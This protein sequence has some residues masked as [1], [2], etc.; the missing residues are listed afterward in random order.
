[1]AAAMTHQPTKPAAMPGEKLDA[2]KMLGH[3]LLARTGK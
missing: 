3:G 2:A 1:M